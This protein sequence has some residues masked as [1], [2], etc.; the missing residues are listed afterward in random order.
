MRD[1]FKKVFRSILF[2]AVIITS[3][4]VS[5][6]TISGIVHSD[7]DSTAVVGASCRLFSG[8]DFL[9]GTAASEK[10]AFELDTDVKSKLRLEIS[11][12]GFNTT[13]IVID[14][15]GDVN[16]GTVYLSEGISLGEVTVNAASINDYRG[17]TIIFPSASEVKASSSALSLFQKLPLSGLEANPINRSLSVD[18]AS[19]VI[20]INGV[21]S[22]IDDFNALQPKDIVKVEY[23]RLTPARYADSS[24]NGFISITL[25]KR[26]DG[27][28]V[29]A[30]G[31]SA[32]TTAFVDANIN[33]SYHQGLSQFSLQYSPTWRNYQEVYDNTVE[34]YIADDFRVDLE[35]HD[36][37]PFHYLGNNTRLKYV[38]TPAINT[39]FSATLSFLPSSDGRRSIAVNNDSELGGYDSYHKSTGKDFAPSLDLFFKKDF[40]DRNAIEVQAVGTLS[41]SDYRRS[42]SYFYDDGS[43]DTYIMNVDSRRRS[44]ITEVCYSHTFSDRTSLSAGYQNT[45]SRSTNTYLTTGYKPVLTENNNYVYARFGQQIDKVYLSLSTGAKLFWIKNDLNRRRFVKNLS[46]VQLSW[47]INDHWAVSGAFRYTP[48]IPSLTS[49][50]DYPQ[51]QTPYLISNGNPDLKVP[52]NF[53]Y[54]LQ[55]TYKTG[56]FSAT[57]LG[58]IV[59]TPHSVVSDVSYLGDR[60]FLSRSVNSR[61][62][63]VYQNDVTLKISDISGFGANLYMSLMHYQSAGDTWKHHLTSFD[64]SISLWW[65][66]GP[67]TVAYWRKLPGKY[68]NGHYVGKD[69]NGD[70]LSFEYK[71]DD[72]WTLGVDWMYMFDTKGTRYPA[73]DYSAVNPSYR[74]RYIK[75][76]G[77]MIVLSAVYSADFGS[78]FRSSRRTLN[79]SDNGSSLLKL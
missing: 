60:L 21:P 24:N 46:T 55:F 73:W 4:P 79:N 32:V 62:R 27:G 12:S 66:K 9:A 50:T 22:T 53:L 39:L 7:N 42:N 23:S 29:Y 25:K 75:N 52:E 64:G 57:Y 76:N 15:G 58:A 43:S 40:N 10:G 26:S 1:L 36:R 78:I 47:N 48:S 77:N 67:F 20:L 51:Q 59:N 11:M 63:R 72:H 49:L 61:Y 31:R 18:G 44:L 17:R 14:R 16:V 71:P 37:N 45:L 74:E 28:S 5:A 65:N 33:A 56:K 38:F 2:P 19:P 8:G 34:S 13:E 68:L 35:K 54:R 30:W 69:E 6:R 3:V 70:A 41:S